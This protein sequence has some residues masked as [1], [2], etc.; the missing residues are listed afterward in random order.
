[1]LSLDK[2]C[3]APTSGKYERFCARPTP[4]AKKSSNQNKQTVVD[5][6]KQFKTTGNS[7]AWPCQS[8]GQDTEGFPAVWKVQ[9][10]KI[11]PSWE[12]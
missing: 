12:E 8:Q 11:R 2:P 6:P 1:M 3:L 4:T 10:K 7:I 5:L 9:S